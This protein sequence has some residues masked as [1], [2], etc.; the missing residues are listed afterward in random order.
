[1]NKLQTNIN[2][3]QN[4][5]QKN[6]YLSGNSTHSQLQKNKNIKQVHYSAD[7]DDDELIVFGLLEQK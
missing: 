3:E 5:F 2:V 4:V 6:P 7:Y 1:M